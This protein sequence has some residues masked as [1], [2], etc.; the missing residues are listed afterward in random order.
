MGVRLQAAKHRFEPRAA[1]GERQARE[2]VLAVAQDVEGDEHGRLRRF[3]V[4]DVQ[5]ALQVHAP[6][7]QLKPGRLSALVERDDLAVEDERSLE[8][9]S[10][11][12]DRPRDR[13][14]LRRLLV[15]VA[16][17]DV[18]GRSLRRRRDVDERTDAVVFR[19][20]DQAL[21]LQGGLGQRG[22][23]RAQFR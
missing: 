11:G 20:V 16:R 10:R 3:G 1:L 15:A 18:H 22:Q 13:G 4:P 17:P 14:K 12:F 9:P 21:L 2:I 5:R 6:L 8:L 7:E 23:H 19:L